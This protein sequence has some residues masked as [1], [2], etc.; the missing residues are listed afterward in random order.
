VICKIISKTLANRLKPLLDR[1]ISINQSA[2]ISDRL[3]TDNALLA[4]ETFHAMKCSSNGKNNAFALK[5]DMSKA[6]DQVEW[7]FLERVML[8]LGFRDS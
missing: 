2:F 6:Y 3:I 7:P 4:F 5:L 1:I 8:R